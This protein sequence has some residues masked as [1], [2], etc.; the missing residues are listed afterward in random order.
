MVLARNLAWGDYGLFALLYGILLFLVNSAGTV[1]TY[2]L[3]LRGATTDVLGVRRLAGVSLL[4]AIAVLVPG[5]L[6]VLLGAS[7]LH[8]L[9]LAAWVALSLVFWQLQ[10]TL[11]RALMARMSFR[12][13]AWGDG[14]RYL[15]QVILVLALA[16]SGSLTLSS[17]FAAV[18]A[19]SALA[20]AVQFVQVRPQLAGLRAEECLPIVRDFW[21]LGR[22]AFSTNVANGLTQQAF[23]WALGL[24]FG[25]PAAGSFQAVTNPLKLFNPVIGG[26]QNLIVPSAAKKRQESGPRSAVRGGLSQIAVG[27]VL[28]IPYLALLVLFPRE[29]LGVLYGFHSPY[30]GLGLALQV[31]V[32]SYGFGYFAQMISF[33]LQGLGLARESFLAQCAATATAAVVGLPLTLLGGLVGA[34]GGLGACAL[35]KAATAVYVVRGASRPPTEEVA[36]GRSV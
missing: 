30:A 21:S 7:I 29:F 27:A 35:A 9:D 14:L 19:T 31:S 36:V 17:A 5:S 22:W 25:T 1:V 20:A 2:P 33:L 23:P 24:L 3:S 16:D 34:M 8:R 15:G 26:A 6:I 32:L 11:R 12:S 18:A 13:A 10:E 4:L 28:L